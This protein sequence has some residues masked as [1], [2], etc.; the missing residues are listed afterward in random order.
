MRALSRFLARLPAVLYALRPRQAAALVALLGIGLALAYA[1]SAETPTGRISGKV[2]LRDNGKPLEG[3]D[4]TLEP[5]GAEGQARRMRYAVSG[6]G[7]RFAFTHVPAGTYT[8][9][10]SSAA[11]TAQ[12]QYVNVDE[13]ETTQIFLEMTRS[14][15]SLALREHQR[16]FGTREKASLSLSGYVDSAKPAGH[17]VLHLNLYRTRLSNV[18]RDSDT[19]EVFDSVGRDYDP[20]IRLPAKILHPRHGIAPARVDERDIRITEGDKEGFFYK[21]LNFGK[22]DAGLYLAD[23]AHAGN[24]AC[25]W[26]L[27]T[28]TALVIKQANRQILAYAVDMRTGTPLPAS[29]VR[30]Y[31]NGA[32]V[33]QGK[34]DGRGL[35][36]LTLPGKGQQAQ[37]PTDEG[38]ST[39]L[40]LVALRGNDEAVV[41]QD[42]SREENSDDFTLHAYTDRPIY[43]PGQRI[44]FKG[45]ARRNMEDADGGKKYS[46]P[47]GMPI[48]VEVRDPS[49]DRILQKRYVANQYGS[50]YGSVDLDPEAATGV[51]TLAMTPPGGDQPETHDI[52]VA[53]YQKPE[54]Q[55][56]VTPQ[57]ARYTRGE[58]VS[59]T[60]S[61]EYYFGAPVAGAKVEYQVYGSPDWTAEFPDDY[62]YDENTDGMPSYGDHENYYGETV[63]NGTT[64]LDENGKAVLTFRAEKPQNGSKDD[65]DAEGPQAE[66]YA[67][68]VT[69]TEGASEPVPADGNVR[70]TS[71]DFHLAVSPEGYVAA[72]NQP[73]S[74]TLTARDYDGKPLAN[75]PIS[76]EMG[77]QEWKRDQD[78][79]YNYHYHSVGTQQAVTGADGRTMVAVTPPHSGELLLKARA[80]D[81]EH[82][83]ILARAN[84]WTTSDGGGDLDTEYTDI[85]LLTD[86][87]HYN[88]G[89]TARVLINATRTGQTVLLTIEGDRVYHSETLKMTQKSVVMRVPVRAGYG[90]NVS[91]VACYVRD[92]KF[93]RS[94][95][96]LRVTMQ[97]HELKVT[98]QADREPAEDTPTANGASPAAQRPLASLARYQPEEKI[99]YRIQTTDAQGHPVPAEFS[100]GVVDEAIYALKED[101]PTALRDAFYPHRENSVQTQYS[102]AV[103]YMGDADKSEPQ[104]TARKKFPDTAFWEP[105]LHTDMEGRAVVSFTLPDNLTTWRATVTAQ[106]LDTRLG[107]AVDKVVVSK[108]FLVRVEKPRFL[109]QRDHSQIVA[110]VHNDTGTSQTALVRLR[111]TNLTIAN[112]PTQT[113][114]LASGQVGQATWNVA[115]DGYGEAKLHVTAWTPRSSGQRQYTD[116]VETSLPIR[117]HGREEVVAYAGELT[118]AHP[119]TEVVRL[120]PAAIPGVSRLTVRVTPS[121]A[122]ALVGALDYLIG[123]PYG[124]TE[125]TMSRFLPD[126]LVQRALRLNGFGSVPQTNELPQMV[127]SGLLRLYR[128]QHKDNDSVNG[129][130]GGW[131]WWEHDAD[132]TWM[133]AYVLYGL[134]T[135][136]AEGYPVNEDVLKSGLKAARK[137][138]ARTL[139]EQRAFLLY[140]LALAGDKQTAR[141]ERPK[142]L[143]KRMGP[144]ALAYVVMLDRLLGQRSTDAANLLTRRIVSEDGMLH[145]NSEKSA[146]SPDWWFGSYNEDDEMA[147]AMG[148]RALL[149]L[150]RNDARVPAILRWLMWK[151]T[152]DYWSSTRDTAWVLA[153][154]CDYLAAQPSTAVGGEVRVRLNGS[155]IQTYTLTPDMRREQELV[156]HVPV[157][158]LR[159]KKNDITLERIGGAS[160]IFYSVELKQTV[161]MED[162]PA[163]SG[164]QFSVKRE[165]LRVK[166]AKAGQD[167]WTLQTEPTHDLLQTGD[168][169]RVRLTLT[170]PR[171]MAYVLI[172]DP[173]P[174]GCEVTERG[175]A[176]E[177]VEWGYWWSSVDVRD[178]RIAFFTRTLP[179]GKHVIEY[180]LRAQTPGAY[181]TLPTLLQAMYAP[182]TRAES[183]ET[184]IEVK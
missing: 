51:Y 79:D 19:A 119:E 153:A 70:V 18:L 138:A 75:V 68:S 183:A 80:T 72:P 182:E 25:A 49:G 14:L 120:D 130:T 22:L 113:L 177:V 23:I 164:S 122:S 146:S 129:G 151:R 71:G 32:V 34:T 134:A 124:C 103:E 40:M 168:N 57:K 125:Q 170:V 147:T 88:P 10:A 3:A 157:S 61:G 85:S 110:L 132:D 162:M 63:T 65:T 180:N 13:G 111:A 31:Q 50:F 118:A 135:A 38:N 67:V 149:A 136:R 109:T 179:K 73:T 66:K 154:L 17:D 60:I 140:A 89:D 115:A 144:E 20:A 16:V 155:V 11:H 184:H 173:F 169:I 26:V 82:H 62:D 137:M 178:D 43:R 145:W 76:L 2:S 156:L 1:F 15:P 106:T 29:D 81:A 139:S 99:T 74:V 6:E 96:P 105:V 92:K 45:I 7:G 127:C 35:A 116:G 48:A 117:A 100:L 77:Y 59:V 123:Y 36:E 9:S 174:A 46:V 128:F 166:P 37:K 150:N 172:E 90:P 55:V 102:F 84:L 28:D 101:D 41:A 86:K 159:P 64:T 148:L 87:R 33:A 176:E 78:G 97:Q 175:D 171:D 131:G 158:Q 5:L 83:V 108:D 52:V 167:S 142:L 141:A 93:Y 56:T 163:L 54:F 133:T 53:S 44:Y 39:R 58:Q 95:T 4:L 143:L 152:G 121:V 160:S 12:N 104:I 181:H 165:F 91:L 30:A 24:T 27:V 112:D 107:R 69:V 94:E 42:I 21:K 8:I 47:T 98:V 126:L 161:A 114:T